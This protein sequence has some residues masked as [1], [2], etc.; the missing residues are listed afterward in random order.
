MSELFI[1]Q[2]YVHTSSIFKTL[3]IDHFSPTLKSSF[4]V[5]QF[6]QI[7]KLWRNSFFQGDQN[8][9]VDLSPS[10][11]L[12]VYKSGLLKL[13]GGS[14]TTLVFCVSRLLCESGIWLLRTLGVSAVSGLELMILF[15]FANSVLEFSSLKLHEWVLSWQSEFSTSKFLPCVKE[16]VD[17]YFPKWSNNF[18]S[19]GDSVWLVNNS[20]HQVSSLIQLLPK[21]KW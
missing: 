3:A 12:W 19:S 11:A 2:H 6:C 9:P 16:Q 7:W 17:Y 8:F 15:V 18:H 14:K 5:F 13:P 10:A 20:F 4:L 21:Q 1:M